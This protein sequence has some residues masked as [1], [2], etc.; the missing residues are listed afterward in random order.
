MNCLTKTLILLALLGFAVAP[1]ALA[2]EQPVDE[3][4]LFRARLDNLMTDAD[5]RVFGARIATRPALHALYER[6]GFRPAWRSPGSSEDLLRAVRGSAADGLDPDDYLLPELERASADIAAGAASQEMRIDFDI[7]QSEALARLL[8]HLMFG[9][10]TPKSFDP[11]WNFTREIGD[12]DPAAFLDE[13]LESGEVYQRIEA[14]KPDHELYLLLR[15]ELARQRDIEAAGEPAAVPDGPKLELGARGPRVAALRV[16]LGLDAE[17]DEFDTALLDRVEQLQASH[18]LDLDGV[19][20]P[21]TLAAVNLT[22][23]EKITLIRVNLER[24]RWYLHDLDPT[25]VF[26]NLAGFQVYYLRDSKLI[27]SSRAIIGKPYRKT[28]VFRSRIT[29]LVL[30]PTWTVPSTILTQ[31]MLPAQRRN[32]SYLDN[33]GIAVIDRNGR[34][35]PTSSIDWSTARPGRFPYDL[36]QGP[37]PDNALGRVKFMFPNPYA[38]Y[39]HDTPSRELFKKSERAF[40]SGC[41]RVADPL[42]LAALLLEDQRDW[43]RA[44]IDKAVAVGKTRTVKL[45]TPVPILITYFTAWV[46]LSGTLQLRRDVYGRDEKVLRGLEAEFQIRGSLAETASRPERSPAP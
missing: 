31:D 13:I 44:A 43:D 12:L 39:L 22:A 30:N 42:D 35:V 8:Y 45:S 36:V 20:G 24:M 6:R 29:Y 4:D 23:A 21:A 3:V 33:K 18:G 2:Q 27:W 38:V 10:V 5:A 28:P 16:R 32:P 7:L 41:I 11:H 14:Q 40:S 26:V 25:F 15:A 46:D 34:V 17:P 37:G 19:V 1:R 9:K